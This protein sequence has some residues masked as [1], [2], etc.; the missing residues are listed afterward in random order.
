M[1]A[2]SKS[3]TRSASI[4]TVAS[5]IWMTQEFSSPGLITPGR[6]KRLMSQ[7]CSTLSTVAPLEQGIEA[8]QSGGVSVLAEGA[9]LVAAQNVVAKA[10]QPGED[11]RVVA[12]AGL[13]LQER[14]VARV[15]QRVLD[16]PMVADRG[17]AALRRG[18][19]IGQIVGHLAGAAP[20]TGL[21]A[22]MQDRT[23]HADDVL[24]P[25]LP[26]GAGNRGFR[27]KDL[28]GS[29]FMPVA[30]V[31][32]RDVGAG[33]ALGGAGGDGIVQQGGLIV[34]QLDDGLD[35]RLGGGRECFFWQCRASR[36]TMQ[37]AMSSSPIN[38]CAAGISL[39]FSSISM[40]ARIMP[41][42]V[43]NA[44]SSWAALRSRKLSKLRLSVFPSSAMVR[45]VGLAASPAR[46]AACRRK[47]CSTACGS[48]P[49]RM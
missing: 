21:G 25:G 35:L 45:R 46:P 37:C 5:G 4:G 16:V 28:D 29:G 31:A 1:S 26:L 40:W 3:L 20:Q 38:R 13:V 8:A 24:D 11:T 6:S 17:G 33:R 27:A 34:L 36:V 7:G 19:E 14:D 23:V 22:A 32:N 43:S 42:S 39:N 18:G 41:A 10:A 2:V 44:C 30:R 48:R 47:T 49:W 12:D 9:D 15:V